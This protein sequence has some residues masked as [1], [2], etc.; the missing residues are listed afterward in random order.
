[1]IFVHY[2]AIAAGGAVTIVMASGLGLVAILQLVVA[3]FVKLPANDDEAAGNFAGRYEPRPSTSSW[4]YG[5]RVTFE[6]GP[7]SAG[8]RRWHIAAAVTALGFPIL[9]GARLA[10]DSV[11]SPG[12]GGSSYWGCWVH[13]GLLELSLQFLLLSIPVALLYLDRLRANGVANAEFIAFA[14]W[15]VP[16]APSALTLLQDGFDLVIVCAMVVGYAGIV[17]ALVMRA[18]AA[19]T[20]IWVFASVVILLVISA[21][22]LEYPLGITFDATL[23]AFAIGYGIYRIE[24]KR[25][26]EASALTHLA[27]VGMETT[28]MFRA[29]LA[30]PD[31]L[32]IRYDRDRLSLAAAFAITLLTIVAVARLIQFGQPVS[33]GASVD[34]VLM[35]AVVVIALAASTLMILTTI[36]G[37][38]LQLRP[39]LAGLMWP[40]LISLSAG[41]VYGFT[42]TEPFNTGLPFVLGAAATT[43]CVLWMM[44]YVFGPGRRRRASEQAVE[45]TGANI[46]ATT[47]Q[48]Q[49]GAERH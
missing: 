42:G 12:C 30:N 41:R 43:V 5:W 32:R 19:R 26:V 31:R 22:M 44:W 28:A 36:S 35:P 6:P 10:Y 16:R 27:A 1:M 15:S 40:A 49:V 46:E 17:V 24:W 4:L 18:S 39:F 8:L 3:R 33:D 7:R 23:S 48:V 25:R 38:A 45:Q 11:G 20:A 21:G 13:G 34:Y 9:F 2:L 47:A 14:V 29:K 37:V